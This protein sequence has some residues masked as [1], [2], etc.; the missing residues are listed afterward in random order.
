MVSLFLIAAL[1]SGSAD[2]LPPKEAK[3]FCDN[4]V[5]AT[6][7]DCERSGIKCGSCDH[8]SG[9]SLDTDTWRC[10]KRKCTCRNGTPAIGDDCDADAN[11]AEICLKCDEGYKMDWATNTC[12]GEPVS[13]TPCTCFQGVGNPE[14][15]AYKE[16][17][18]I[19]STVNGKRE[20]TIGCPEERRNA[21]VGCPQPG[22]ILDRSTNTCRPEENN[23]TA[24]F[25]QGCNYTGKVC[26]MSWLS[27]TWGI[28]E[29]TM[30]RRYLDGPWDKRNN[31]KYFASYDAKQCDWIESGVGSIRRPTNNLGDKNYKCFLRIRSHVNYLQE[32][33]I[34]MDDDQ[35]QCFGKSE[36]TIKGGPQDADKKIAG[37][38]VAIT[39]EY[40]RPPHC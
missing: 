36:H 26:H 28:L 33:R 15:L 35:V 8:T 29:D 30:S 6:G 1:G 4:G 25:Y 16:S 3:C 17:D 38:V 19:L 18:E 5:A 23:C 10:I 21:C 22:W 2:C 9:Y 39:K 32:F 7:L 34:L 20:K 12:A 11:G 13:G 24:S 14:G 31:F 40:P 27:N 37:K